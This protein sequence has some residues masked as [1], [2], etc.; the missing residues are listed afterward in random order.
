M[1]GR[2]RS[3]PRRCFPTAQVLVVGGLTP[4]PDASDESFGAAPL[5][6]TSEAEVYD[7][8]TAS[9]IAGAGGRLAAAARVPPGGVRRHH[10]RRQIPDP[11]R[12]RRDRPD[13]ASAAFGINTGAVPGTRI[14]PFDTSGT[15]PQSAAGLGGGLGA[16][17]LRPGRARGHAHDDGRLHARRLSGRGP[18]RRRPRRRRRH[19]LDG[20]PPPRPIPTINRAEVSRALETPPRFVALPTARMGATLTRRSTTIAG[21]CG[22]ARSRPTDPA[23][24][25]TTGLSVGG[26]VTDDAGDAGDGAT[27]AVPH[28]DGPDRRPVDDRSHHHRHRRLRRDDDQHGPGAAAADADAERRAS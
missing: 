9:F 19:R 24:D 13:P 4:T 26:T 6:L 21:S 12:R 23:G 15:L 8:A 3:T 16:A 11:P 17:R 7:P 27:D 20:H 28:G 10:Q 1:H 5:Y 2:A 18:V 25:Y 14:V 22:A